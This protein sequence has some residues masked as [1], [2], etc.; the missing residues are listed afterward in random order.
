MA[1]INAGEFHGFIYDGF[2]H[3]NPLTIPFGC[4]DESQRS[5]D[6]GEAR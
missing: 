2:Y 5:A 4:N 6:V 3:A 1:G